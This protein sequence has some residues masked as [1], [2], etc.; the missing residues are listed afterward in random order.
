MTDAPTTTEPAK[1]EDTKDTIEIALVLIRHHQYTHISDI[2]DAVVK[3]AELL[4][5]TGWSRSLVVA[6]AFRCV[7]KQLKIYLEG[8]QE[9]KT[10]LP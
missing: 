2:H 1:N 8:H 10:H 6:D 3:A 5:V 9:P 7:C 4:D